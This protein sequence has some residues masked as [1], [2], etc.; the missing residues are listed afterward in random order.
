M[1]LNRMTRSRMMSHFK[2]NILMW[3]FVLMMWTLPIMVLIID[4]ASICAD[5]MKE[6]ELIIVVDITGPV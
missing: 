3:L 1:G 4:D 2:I 5:N 6:S